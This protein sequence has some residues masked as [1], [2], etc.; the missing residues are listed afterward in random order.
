MRKFSVFLWRAAIAVALFANI[1]VFAQTARHGAMNLRV[2]TKR[3]EQR[4]LALAEFGK[5]PFGG[6]SRVAFS[7]ADIQ[8]RN[9]VIALMREAGLQVKIDAAGNIIGRREGREPKLPSIIF[10]SHIDSVPN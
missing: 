10:G 4:I 1:H 9:Y 3:L 5:N 6:V 7:E 8:G 2:N